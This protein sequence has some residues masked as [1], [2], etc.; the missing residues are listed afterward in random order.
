MGRRRRCSQSENQMSGV[1]NYFS[2]GAK[3]YW[4]IVNKTFVNADWSMQV[5]L[6]FTETNFKPL[7]LITEAAIMLCQ[8]PSDSLSTR[9]QMGVL[10]R[11][12]L[13]HTLPS[14]TTWGRPPQDKFAKYTN[15][16]MNIQCKQKYTRPRAHTPSRAQYTPNHMP[17]LIFFTLHY[18][19]Q[20]VCITKTKQR[21]YMCTGPCESP[22]CT[23]LCPWRIKATPWTS[24]Q[25]THLLST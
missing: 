14:E 23:Q 20:H 5:L 16:C 17:F 11:R 19:C 1:T 15:A 2:L 22:R 4:N 13:T 12:R 10:P 3:L 6:H 18:T 25:F 7:R 8:F 9:L 21:E 24:M